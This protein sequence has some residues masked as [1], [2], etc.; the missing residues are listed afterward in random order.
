MVLRLV[1]SYTVYHYRFRFAPGEDGKKIYEEAKNDLILT[2]G[3]LEL[4][5]EKR[6]SSIM[7]EK[8]EK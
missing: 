7:R 2:A 5:F 1:M 6:E 8:T 3:P 4:V